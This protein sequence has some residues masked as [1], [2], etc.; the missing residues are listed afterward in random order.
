[1]DPKAL[2][3]LGKPELAFCN[4]RPNTSAFVRKIVEANTS[5]VSPAKP[6]TAIRGLCQ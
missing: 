6:S 4:L 1:M 5:A 2:A 3:V